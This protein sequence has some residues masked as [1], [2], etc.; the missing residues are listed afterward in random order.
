MCFDQ[1]FKYIGISI[2]VCL[3]YLFLNVKF[4]HLIQ[5]QQAICTFTLKPQQN[6]VLSLDL[7]ER[8]VK[9]LPVQLLKKAN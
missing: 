2:D 4:I 1:H 9:E 3:K 5:E 6:A 8:A 7:G